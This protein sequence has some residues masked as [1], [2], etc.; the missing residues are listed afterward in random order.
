MRK[1][2]A[3]R[4]GVSRHPKPNR[5][6]GW[7]DCVRGMNLMPQLLVVGDVER[8]RDVENKAKVSISCGIPSG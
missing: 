1:A 8:L 5:H 7:I 2:H 4:R 6:G 3:V